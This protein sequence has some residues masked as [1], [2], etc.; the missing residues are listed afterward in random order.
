MVQHLHN[1]QV[2]AGVIEVWHNFETQRNLWIFTQATTSPEHPGNSHIP[3][4]ETAISNTESANLFVKCQQ[5]SGLHSRFVWPSLRSDVCGWKENKNMQTVRALWRGSL[6]YRGQI[7]W[8]LRPHKARN[9]WPSDWL[10]EAELVLEIES[11]VQKTT[12]IQ[13]DKKSKL[14]DHQISQISQCLVIKWV[15]RYFRVH[16]LTAD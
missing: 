16:L 7:M 9:Q 2:C 15:T 8:N 13:C 4:D 1:G 6:R 11:K 10:L 12:N 14:L 5:H 3:S